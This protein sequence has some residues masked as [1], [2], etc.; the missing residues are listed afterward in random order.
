LETAGQQRRLGGVTGKGFKPGQ[1]GNPSG[2][3]KSAA[4]L[5]DLL[6][7]KYGE[8]GKVLV[9]RLEAFS[10]GRDRKLAMASTEL[11]LAYLVGKPTQAMEHSG[12]GGGPLQVVFGGRYRPDGSGSAA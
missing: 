10:A 12:E 9:E 8:D 3:P 4:N 6:K 1:S 5:R 2:R 7:R 11:L